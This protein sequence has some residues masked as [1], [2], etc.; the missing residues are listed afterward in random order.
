MTMASKVQQALGEVLRVCR[1]ECGLTVETVGAKLKLSTQTIYAYELAK[2][3]VSV[4]RLFELA[5]LYKTEPVE[6]LRAVAQRLDANPPRSPSDE[7]LAIA[8]RLG[9]DI[10]RGAGRI[11]NPEVQRAVL[12]LLAEI[13]MRQ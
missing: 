12:N 11:R 9:H 8:A 13:A 1:L 4:T 5:A 6:I 7:E 3:S 10:A 2:A